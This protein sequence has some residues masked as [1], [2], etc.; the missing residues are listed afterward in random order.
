MQP[1][2]IP[3]RRKKQDKPEPVKQ[4]EIPGY[5]INEGPQSHSRS[6]KEKCEEPVVLVLPTGT[7]Q[8]VWEMLEAKARADHQ[9][10]SS[11]DSITSV[12]E[13]A[14]R[15]FRAANASALNRRDRRPKRK[16]R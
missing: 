8:Y 1:T 13:N 9:R 5:P 2:E 11:I 7:F 10:Y 6:L 12:A 14:V 3:K 15:L 4:Y 16:K